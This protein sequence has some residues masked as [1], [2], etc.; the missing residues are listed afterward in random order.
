MGEPCCI[1]TLSHDVFDHIFSKYISLSGHS[2]CR[3]TCST[4]H[5]RIPAVST[6]DFVG[7]I[8]LR[9]DIIFYNLVRARL[10]RKELMQDVRLA[11]KIGSMEFIQYFDYT[12]RIDVWTEIVQVACLHDQLEV[13]K[14]M[15]EKSYAPNLVYDFAGIM[16]AAKSF[17]CMEWI[18]AEGAKLSSGDIA[19]ATD[20]GMLD[21]IRDSVDWTA[22][23]MY[24]YYDAMLV[25][26]TVLLEW[27]VTKKLLP[28]TSINIDRPREW[29]QPV[30]PDYLLDW[31]F[32]HYPEVF[33]YEAKLVLTDYA[34]DN[35]LITVIAW[36]H[37]NCNIYTLK[38][39]RSNLGNSK[40]KVSVIEGHMYRLVSWGHF[41]FV[42]EVYDIMP[43]FKIEIGYIIKVVK[44]E[45]AKIQLIIKC[46]R[47]GPKAKRYCE[48][49]IDK[50]NYLLAE[51]LLHAGYS[52][53]AEYLYK[54]VRDETIPLWSWAF[55]EELQPNL[56]TLEYAAMSSKM[57]VWQYRHILALS[58]VPSQP[59]KVESATVERYIERCM[60]LG[61]VELLKELSV[62]QRVGFENT[63][64]SIGS[65][66]N[67]VVLAL[68]TLRWFEDIKR[69]EWRVT[70]HI[71]MKEAIRVRDTSLIAWLR[72]VGIDWP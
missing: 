37:R 57:I 12:V 16:L 56:N 54:L 49:A 5:H 68:A 67:L 70:S 48:M 36:L 44:R 6:D 28:S 40:Y 63:L 32:T 72:Y 55:E 26:N 34:C 35:L 31:I 60:E 2:A 3:I 13:V 62:S 69:N 29:I 30:K 4:L 47:A 45:D 38:Q 8:M 19:C 17:R 59:C 15:K 41:S 61:L 7:D 14:W 50:H 42:G 11:A 27:M 71:I 33:T 66:A 9:G 52:F 18:L 24:V 51:H 53:S 1:L 64:S 20:V 65:G 10:T 25:G 22:I 58:T 23:H 46:G 43:K 21:Y 39:P